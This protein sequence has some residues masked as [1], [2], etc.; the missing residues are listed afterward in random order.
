MSEIDSERQAKLSEIPSDLD[1][2][3]DTRTDRLIGLSDGIFAFA[4]TLLAVNVD[5]PRLASNLTPAE[6][7]SSVLELAP[8][9]LIYVTSFLLVGVYWQVHRRTFHFIKASDAALTWLNLLQLMCVAFLPVAA[10]LFDTHTNV[11][12]VIVVYAATL[13][14]IGLV[15][16][17]LWRHAVSAKL[18]VENLHP[19]YIDYYFFRGRVTITIY[20]LMLFVGIIAPEYAQLVLLLMFI[21]PFLQRIFRF[22]YRNKYV[23]QT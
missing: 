14:S 13:L 2:D 1:V 8:D 16:L 11:S 15:G 9:F 18:M 20:V 6:V 5:L 10:G 21:Y 4:M 19:I 23:E 3:P 12:I 7:T 17:L 22:L